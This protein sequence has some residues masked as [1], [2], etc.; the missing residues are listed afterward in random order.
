MIFYHFRLIIICFSGIYR[1]LDI[2]WKDD[3]EDEIEE[4]LIPFPQHELEGDLESFNRLFSEEYKIHS[5][6]Q[7]IFDKMMIGRSE[8]LTLLRKLPPDHH[9]TKKL[10]PRVKLAI[11]IVL[12][13]IYKWNMSRCNLGKLVTIKKLIKSMSIFVSA[14][15]KY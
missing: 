1:T 3:L 8:L 14:S 7:T 11:S 5:S 15:I 6:F 10:E 2:G 13:E 9:F 12:A 4:K